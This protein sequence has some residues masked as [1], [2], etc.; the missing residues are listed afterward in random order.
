MASC[1]T[2]QALP[3][4]MRYHGTEWHTVLAYAPMSNG[5]TERIV[6]TMKCSIGRF[7]KASGQG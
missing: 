7:V 6:G 3:Y 4:F 2:A 5:K 1:F